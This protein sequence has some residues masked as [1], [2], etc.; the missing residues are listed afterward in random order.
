MRTAISIWGII[1]FVTI[2]IVGTVLWWRS[3]DYDYSNLVFWVCELFLWPIILFMSS[4][5]WS[6]RKVDFF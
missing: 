5:I 2:G 1:M 4:F 3:A 6:L